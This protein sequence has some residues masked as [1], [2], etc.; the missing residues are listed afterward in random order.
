MMTQLIFS[1]LGFL[2]IDPMASQKLESPE[3]TSAKVSDDNA[4]IV[5]GNQNINKLRLKL[6][7]FKEKASK[8][9]CSILFSNYMHSLYF[10]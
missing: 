6:Q 9:S 4:E 8:R 7:L 1:T 10:E 5:S 2:S 3:G